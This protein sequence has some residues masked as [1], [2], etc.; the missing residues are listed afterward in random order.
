M[1]KQPV[2]YIDFNGN[3][4]TETLY[5]NL[6]RAESIELEATKSGGLSEWIKTIDA[7]KNPKAIIDAFKEMIYKSYG[8]RTPDGSRFLKNDEMS[9]AFL[10]TEAYSSLFVMLI[11][12]PEFAQHFVNNL[13]HNPKDA[14]GPT[15][16]QKTFTESNAPA[17]TRL[18]VVDDAPTV[19]TTSAF[20]SAVDAPVKPVP[21][22]DEVHAE[23]LRVARK[24]AEEAVAEATRLGAI[25]QNEIGEV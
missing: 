19:A 14:K 20:G 23:R 17:P 24:R 22:E 6:T 11:S 5:F 10:A 2:T 7:A 4:V 16:V 9:Q 13:L 15:E 1:L 3:E 8:E 18:S 21:T 12:D 25:G